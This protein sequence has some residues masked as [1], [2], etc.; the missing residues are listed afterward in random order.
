MNELALFAGAGG[1][2]LGGKLLGFTT[3]CA[4]EINAFAASVL[5]SRQNDGCLAPFP[6]W[7]DIRT[8]DGIPWRGTVDLVSGGFPCQDIALPGPGGGIEGTRSGLWKEMARIIGEVRP[9]FVIVENSTAIRG[10]GIN[11]VLGDLAS[12]GYDARWGNL[13]ASGVGAPH[14]RNRFWLVANARGFVPLG[15]QVR[16]ASRGEPIC[17]TEPLLFPAWSQRPSA[18]ADLPRV[19][20]GMATRLDAV[21]AIGNGQVPQVAAIAWETLKP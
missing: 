7:D 6:V 14:E 13:A 16:T 9:A 19:D 15:L 1:G 18:L 3:V 4:V 5:V 2:I 10:R 17:E 21:E 12:M 11:V 20:D 8:F